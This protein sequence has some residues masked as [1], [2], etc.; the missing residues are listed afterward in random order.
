[1][2]ALLFIVGVF[3]QAQVQE[4]PLDEQRWEELTRNLD[5]SEEQRETSTEWRSPRHLVGA[6][7]VKVALILVVV[8]L[9]VFLMLRFITPGLFSRGKGNKHEQIEAR[10]LE[11]L[12]RDELDE[13][14][15]SAVQARAFRLAVRIYYL[16]IVRELSARRFIHW[17]PEK[18]NRQYLVEMSEHP[19]QPLFAQSTRTYERVWFGEESLSGSR[20]PEIESGFQNLIT[21]IASK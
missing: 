2:L 10:P 20:F 17:H 11:T 18:T 13:A 19:L 6:D 5:Y 12:K 14:L 9:L 16:I 4:R 1:M 15:R 7:W 8:A 3:S 21:R